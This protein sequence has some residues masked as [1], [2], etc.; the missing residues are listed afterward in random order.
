MFLRFDIVINSVK[1]YQDVLDVTTPFSVRSFF[2]NEVQKN[3]EIA[4]EKQEYLDALNRQEVAQQQLYVMNTQYR[5]LYDE[6]LAAKKDQ[7]ELGNL[8]LKEEEVL[9]RIFND[10]YGSDK[11]W[12]L[13]MEVDLLGQR[14]ERIQAAYY[15]WHG[16]RVYLDA[17]VKQLSWSTRRWAQISRHNVQHMIVSHPSNVILSIVANCTIMYSLGLGFTILSKLLWVKVKGAV[18]SHL[19]SAFK[20]VFKLKKS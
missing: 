12:K 13:E 16:A 14:K 18:E 17:A 2:V 8:R 5:K 7:E 10:S 19:Y 6:V 1:E 9:G 3:A 15:R 20:T 4:K 11:E